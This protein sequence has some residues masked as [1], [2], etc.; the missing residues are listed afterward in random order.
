MIQ[1]SKDLCT[2]LYSLRLYSKPRFL[3]VNQV[4]INHADLGERASQVVLMD[5]IFASATQV[6][7]WLGDSD[8]RTNSNM[9]II[10]QIAD[11]HDKTG[12]RT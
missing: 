10:R 3:W 11:R 5:Q 6:V 1:I 8:E 12:S 7:L 9:A 2:A 4:C